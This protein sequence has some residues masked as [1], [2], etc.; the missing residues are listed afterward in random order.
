VKFRAFA[1]GRGALA[2]YHNAIH[3]NG[4]SIAQDH[5]L[6]AQHLIGYYKAL[7]KDVDEATAGKR[8]GAVISKSLETALAH[9]KTAET[10]ASGKDATVELGVAKCNLLL[11]QCRV[12]D[13]N[14]SYEIITL[15]QNAVE[16]YH[17]AAWVDHRERGR[18][19]QEAAERF[20]LLGFN[21]E[22]LARQATD[23]ELRDNLASLA[24][25]CYMGVIHS[26]YYLTKS[27]V[28]SGAA[29]F[30][31]EGAFDSILLY[32]IF[33]DP[34]DFERSLTDRLDAVEGAF[35]LFH[36][37]LWPTPDGKRL[38]ASY[39]H[40]AVADWVESENLAILYPGGTDSFMA[41]LHHASIGE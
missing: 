9:Y 24:S 31:A 13:W 11:A 41:R 20:L 26:Y 5:L 18:I 40:R 1:F 32:S 38:F 23:P 10:L 34:K 37:M 27:G 3:A 12:Y 25:D 30:A 7:G 36:K 19:L 14:Q 21:S 33:H 8:A 15:V 35:D 4:A 39:A 6:K 16:R 22:R 29:L 28:P 17:A 2:E